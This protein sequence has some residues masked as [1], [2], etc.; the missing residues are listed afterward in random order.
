MAILVPGI[1][2]VG[3]VPHLA[4]LAAPRRLLI[5]EA[6][7]PQNRALTDKELRDAYAFP[8]NVYRVL[9][10]ENALTLLPT[11][12]AKDAVAAL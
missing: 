7:A 3:D 6:R 11:F 1:L 8:R 9:Q 10:R 5:A 2:R 12:Q 4:A